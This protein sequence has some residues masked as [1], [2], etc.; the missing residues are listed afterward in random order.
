MQRREFIKKSSLVSAAFLVPDF[1][2][3]FE[4]YYLDTI[5][6]RN[7]VIIQLSGGNDW[8]NTVVP[9]EN[10]IYYNKRK[11]IAIQKNTIIS[12]NEQFGFHPSLQSLQELFSQGNMCIINGVGYPNPDRSHFRS[13]DIW[14]TGS[15]SDE[16]LTTGW[17]GRLLD[18]NCMGCQNPY[19]AI[20]TD[21][22][23]SLALKGN[24]KKGIA[25][26][27]I[28]QL[29]N[30][31][32]E[33]FFKNIL[34]AETNTM[35][36]EDSLG[37]LYKTLI[38]TSSSAKYIFETSKQFSNPFVY[39]DSGFARQLKTIAGFIGSGLQ[40]RVY[41]LSL[42]GFD[43]HINQVKTQE[44]LLK[45]YAEGVAAFVNN[46][47]SMNK[48]KDTLLMTFSEFGRRVEQNSSGGTDHGTAGNVFIFGD[49]LKQKGIYNP[50]PDLNQLEDGD[51]KFSIDFRSIY[52]TLLDNWLGIKDKSILQRDFDKL[53]FV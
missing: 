14:Q 9:F 51:L 11:T 20:E 13:M 35:L 44:N 36:N 4:K 15:N 19:L 12:L 45:Q 31:T 8:L 43:T 1:L 5:T 26:R 46:L 47:K 48:F 52:A 21:D 32:Q 24:S 28:R 34:D 53:N 30:Q 16:Y 2:K 50:A 7:I 25:V 40:T 10:D 37:Y 38:E 29:Y 41:Y 33:P 49:N 39:P 18:S 6:D 17:I 23:L 22:S 27:D 3:P 42:G